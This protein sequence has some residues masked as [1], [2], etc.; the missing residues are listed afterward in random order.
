MTAPTTTSRAK[1]PP[2]KKRPALKPPTVDQ[3]VL[4]EYVPLDQIEPNPDNIRIDL[5]D[6]DDLA[7]S[8][9]DHGVIQP[10]IGYRTADGTVMLIAGHRRH[11]ASKLAGRTD[12]PMV[13]RAQPDRVEL[14][15]QMLAENNQ[16]QG[17]DPIEEARALLE[18]KKS[19]RRSVK[20]IAA[21]VNRSESWVRDR[22]ALV[23]KLPE[24]MWPMIRSGELTVTDATMI[25]TTKG[26][27]DK[28][29][30][31]LAKTE[32]ELLDRKARDLVWKGKVRAAL[33]QVNTDHPGVP[34]TTCEIY[35]SGSIGSML[36]RPQNVEPGPWGPVRYGT[37]PGEITDPPE[38]VTVDDQAI[39][40]G[41]TSAASSKFA[42]RFE[43]WHLHPETLPS[44]S[45]M[46][47]PP[48][49]EPAD[50]D[51]RNEE[52]T[53]SLEH[54]MVPAAALPDAPWSVEADSLHLFC[55]AHR[56][57]TVP[58]SNTPIAACANP[59]LHDPD[60]PA[61]LSW[62]QMRDARLADRTTPLP[63]APTF[64]EIFTTAQQDALGEAIT[65]VLNRVDAGLLQVVADLPRWPAVTM[66]DDGP[67]LDTDELEDLVLAEL[68]RA[69][70]DAD[71][72]DTIGDTAPILHWIATTL[73]SA[74]VELPHGL[75][76]I[77]GIT[78]L[79]PAPDEEGAA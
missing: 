33:D 27:T 67:E 78:D 75:G 61:R 35:S 7:A 18:I 36:I 37:R 19:G 63:P 74:D 10:A 65:T 51:L 58:W 16:R 44:T 71:Q 23:E 52:Y 31:A 56:R 57:A 53:P 1:K 11:A 60:N 66:T 68:R 55:P 70:V 28:D 24:S 8:I 54:D 13:I 72:A 39:V 9:R 46:P 40:L 12:M 42:T 62:D 41:H 45:F 2:A 43:I 50:G 79:D 64:T 20:A 76:P 22:L 34:V 29:R 59:A 49:P 32:S 73:R 25:A 17:L 77:I 5:G 6:L 48:R 15:E 38:W 30:N 14:L 47:F 21:T 3:Q 4:S 26:L 69:L